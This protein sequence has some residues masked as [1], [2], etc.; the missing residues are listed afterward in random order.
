MVLKQCG[1]DVITLRT[2]YVFN[3]SIFTCA[4]V[5]KRYSLPGRRAGSPQ[6]LSSL[7]SM[8]NLTPASLNISVSERAMRWLRA[9]NEPRQPTQYNTSSSGSPV[10]ASLLE[11]E[12]S[13]SS[14]LNAG[15]P[16]EA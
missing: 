15:S 14:T 6:Q 16:C 11:P 10:G 1:Q 2:P 9:S 5:W 3:S 8:A 4:S 13:A 12:A 7:P